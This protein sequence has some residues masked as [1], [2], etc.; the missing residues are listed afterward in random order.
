MH[1]KPSTYKTT[2]SYCGVGCGIVIHKS[3]S[4]KLR[5]EGDKD[6]PVNKGMLCSKGRNLLHVVNDKSDRILH[7]MM[8]KSIHDDFE[9][10]SWDESLQYIADKVSTTINEHGPD[11]IGFYVSGQC[12]TEEYYITNKLVK[13]FIGTNNIDTNSRLCMSSAVMGYKLA[14]GD[15]IV[16]ASYEDIELADCFLISGANPAWCHPILFRRLENHKQQNPDTKLIVIDPRVTDSCSIADKHL[17][18][19]PGTDITL[20]N[21]IA[22][23]LIDEELVD[24]DYINANA[25]NF[26]SLCNVIHSLSLSD[27]A[28]TC[29]IS[30]EDIIETA[31]M[32]GNAKGFISMWAMGLNQSSEGVN[33][34]LSLLN[35]SIL[36][37]QIGKPGAGP[38]SLTG[39][40][41]AMGGREVGGMATLLAAHHNLANPEHRK[42]VQQFWN[43]KEI[44]GTPGLTAT[45]MISALEEEKLKV[46]WIICTNPMVSLPNL[47][48]T[49]KAFEK[50]ELVIVQDISNKSDSLDFAHIA[51]PASGWL[52]KE[53]TMT[54]SERRIT[55]LNKVVKAP[56]EALSDVDIL[57]RFAKKMQYKG[58]DYSNT[59][60]IFKEYT[61]L[62][63]GTHID[64]SA[65]TYDSLKTAGS[66]QWPVTAQSPQGTKRIFTNGKF[67][68]ENG[69]A[70]LTP[71]VAAGIN[72]RTSREHPF[73][74]TTGRVRDQWHTMTRT[75]KVNKLNDHIEKPLLSISPQDALNAGIK[76]S[77]MITV[78]N[79]RGS[80]QLEAKISSDVKPGVLFVPMHWGKIVNQKFGR[81]NNITSSSID[82][83]SKQPE[84]KFSAV[85]IKKTAMQKRKIIIIGSGAAAYSF[86]E[87]H[88]RYNKSDQVVV[89]SKEKYPFYN[90][91]QLPDYINENKEWTSLL[92]TSEEELFNLDIELKNETCIVSIDKQ[93]KQVTDS[94]NAVHAYDKLIIATGSKP[95][96][97]KNVQKLKN[98]F[99]IRTREDADAIKTTILKNAVN[100]ITIIGSGIL[101][102]EM[103][104]AL[105]E[106][107]LHTTL[108]ARG[109]KLMSRQLDSTAASI[110]AKALSEKGIK[111][112]FNHSFKE[113]KASETQ[114]IKIDFE[115]N[116]EIETDLLIFAIGTSPVTSLAKEAGLNVNKG[117]AVNEFMQSSDP[118]IFALGEVA[119][120][121]GELYGI[122]TAAEDQAVACAN[123]LAGNYFDHYKGSLSE[124]ILKCS[125]LKLC[126]LGDVEN[127]DKSIEEIVLLDSNKGY[128]K[129]CFVQNDRLIGTI[130][131]GDTGEYSKFR[132]LIKKKTELGDERNL[133]LRSAE[134]EEP[135]MG[136]LV[137]S[138]NRVG[139]GNLEYFIQNGCNNFEGLMVLTKAGTGC[140]SCKP[141]IKKILADN[142]VEV[143]SE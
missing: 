86:I 35:L 105:N 103:A 43:G 117:V 81:A 70:N 40:P 31:R 36:T 111:L 113:I 51:L 42:K 12:L 104:D 120:H 32:I 135:I 54:N 71:V 102:I 124:N 78:F 101:G 132:D 5:L 60:E 84:F 91:I 118:D 23:V 139:R 50:A 66:I 69:K 98:T 94:N 140:G 14:F 88:R 106:L 8:R 129:K 24:Y 44:S 9:Q 95:I 45:E 92:K 63:K 74:L 11:S 59:E 10:T 119:E 116:R 79:T 33:K 48:R 142:T 96:I 109:S 100:H 21:A 83:I 73:V 29:G 108:V 141:E 46:V 53:G 122:T 30:V 77:E 22:K 4:G 16:P 65:L 114:K 87:A 2:C 131:M 25:N 64:I 39:Q 90:R 19:T 89:F 128:Y 38:L 1:N 80:M 62:T 17:Q 49:E 137:C 13:G 72:E 125:G 127:T 28:L 26:D 85:N 18:I 34:N 68:T 67:Y 6:H 57:C 121:K 93:N 27:A 99:T 56:G 3:P 15:D 112:L 37:G 58:F 7:P 41:N 138:C 47:L 61:R 97:P 76:D 126:T 107:G 115:A 52:E 123:F 136:D 143:D 110:L 75:G 130:L 134:K 20:T 55:Y 82:P 133:L